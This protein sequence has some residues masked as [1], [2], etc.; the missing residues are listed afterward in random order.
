LRNNNFFCGILKH[1][2]DLISNCLL[3]HALLLKTNIYFKTS[4]AKKQLIWLLILCGFLA[5][6]PDV[7]HAAT[8]EQWLSNPF[9]AAIQNLLY[10]VFVFVGWFT[11]IATTMFAYAVDSRYLSGPTGLLNLQ[12]TYD[13]WK[14]V[15]DIINVFFILALLFIAFA[16]IFQIDGYSDKKVILKLIYAALLVNF[17]FPIA[18][19]IIDFA[20]IPMYFFIQ[21]ILGDGQNASMV[22]SSSLSASNLEA[23]ILPAK[24]SSDV[25]NILLAIV[26]LFIFNITILVLAFQFLIRVVALVILVIFSPIGFVASGIPG[27]KSYGKKW[28]S[29]FMNYVLFGPIAMF[30]LVVAT[31]LFG[32]ISGPSQ[33]AALAAQTAS[34]TSPQ[35][36]FVAAVVLFSIPIVMIWMIIGMAKSYSI[37][38]AS[39]S[40]GYAKKFGNWSKKQGQ[41]SYN[42]R[43]TRGIKKGAM[44]RAEKAPILKN[45]TKYGDEKKAEQEALV[46]G[47]VGDGKKGA[48]KVQ[49]KLYA[50]KVAEQE[51]KFD[52]ERA[53]ESSLRALMNDSNAD[54]VKREA[55]VRSLSKKDALRTGDDIKAAR[56]AIRESNSN[57]DTAKEKEKDLIKKAGGEIYQNADDLANAIGVLGDDVK[58]VGALVD[59]ANGK[60]LNMSPDQ[61]QDIVKANPN[62]KGK[63]DSKLKKEGKIGVL[64]EAEIKEQ[65]ALIST[66]VV[67][68]SQLYQERFGKM[69]AK[70]IAKIDGLNG[71]ATSPMHPELE[72]FIK[73]Q[74]GAGGNWSPKD[75]QDAFSELSSEQKEVW[76]KA[77]LAPTK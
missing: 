57:I 28:W 34:S 60:A 42:N 76:R 15:R 19:V 44:E 55:A 59:K 35:P 66:G 71:D 20:N 45:F 27:M 75:H 2:F 10:A 32:A 29:N 7:I 13:M 56:K 12:A 77:G 49:D 24:D 21:M 17:S 62:I 48:Q 65:G 70:E 67:T 72:R 18:R 52:D 23:I 50:K 73:T 30:M 14:F 11:S 47:Y 54:K 4:K 16:F 64:I 6:F 51:K 26:F 3:V 69:S 22:L 33:A 8:T 68:K 9:Y 25:T 31:N 38:G 41:R 46:A 1:I 74:T 58:G 37:A 39:I 43:L 40:A 5:F 63:L 53:S 36:G 61:Y